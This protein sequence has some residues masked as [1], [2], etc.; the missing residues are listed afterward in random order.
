M[1]RKAKYTSPL[2]KSE[3]IIYDAIAALPE[4]AMWK[5][6]A[7]SAS[8]TGYGQQ[9]AAWL[10]LFEFFRDVVGLKERTESAVGLIELAKSAGWWISHA[11]ICWVAERYR[12][13]HAQPD[14]RGHCTTGPAL[15]FV[16]GSKIYLQN[17]IVLPGV[18]VS[19]PERI[20][21]E[22]IVK[23]TNQEIRTLM[24]KALS[25]ER[26]MQVLGSKLVSSDSFG[27]LRESSLAERDQTFRIRFIKVKNGTVEP[28]GT[29]KDY[30]LTVP[31]SI[32]TC[33]QGVAWSYGVDNPKNVR[34][35][36]T[37]RT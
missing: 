30:I 7:I 18:V 11:G 12:V 25:P 4:D 9:D 6:V 8:E 16:D 23:E 27:E 14:G 19:H 31:L 35:Q 21:L 24:M 15:E 10:A 2:T 5:S 1:A 37:I 3:Q 26:L 22:T 20:T 36:E 28:D 29:R 34:W 32:E 13:I 33:E 17:G